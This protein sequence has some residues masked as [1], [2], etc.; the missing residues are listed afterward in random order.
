MTKKNKQ[1]TAILYLAVQ[2][3]DSQQRNL[4]TANK[5]KGCCAMLC[6]C[7]IINREEHLLC[8]IHLQTF[9]KVLSLCNVGILSHYVHP[10]N[11]VIIRLMAQLD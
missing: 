4:A 11:T 3:F 8:F 5:N 6:R 1:K 10:N 9:A 7:T 2:V